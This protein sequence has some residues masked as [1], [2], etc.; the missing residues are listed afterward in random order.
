MRCAQNTFWV[1]RGKVA[2]AARYR[3][4]SSSSDHL[5]DWPSV[6]SAAGSVS[7]IGHFPL[8]PLPERYAPVIEVGEE[9]ISD[10]AEAIYLVERE[11]RQGDSR[12]RSISCC[13][14]LT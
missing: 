14:R 8:G 13:L 7:G 2:K 5:S 6:S 3:L 1:N 4:R 11:H 10:R 9:A 12:A